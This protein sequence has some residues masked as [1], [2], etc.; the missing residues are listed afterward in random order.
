MT[1]KDADFREWYDAWFEKHDKDFPAQ[2]LYECML[3]AFIAGRQ[4]G[5]VD[6]GRENK[7]L[8]DLKKSI[9]EYLKY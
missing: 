7:V 4:Q 9:E 1:K 8:E 3:D 6:I 5:H 2:T